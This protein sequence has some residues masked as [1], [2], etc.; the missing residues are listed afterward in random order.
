MDTSNSTKPLSFV[1]SN[2]LDN[3]YFRVF[4]GVLILFPLSSALWICAMLLITLN[5]SGDIFPSIL[6]LT[7]LIGISGAWLRILKRNQTMEPD[8]RKMTRILLM[9]GLGTC[10][11]FFTI[12][13]KGGGKDIL[14]VTTIIAFY[15]PALL[16]T[17]ML[18]GTPHIENEEVKA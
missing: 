10:L 1:L 3:T 7:G 12:I 16:G 15:I 4:F 5:F 2:I 8:V 14:H 9:I 13:I 11:G 17:L 6:A 18:I